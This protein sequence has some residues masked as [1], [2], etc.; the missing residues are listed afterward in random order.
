[1][2]LDLVSGS[3]LQNSS[4]LFSID[5]L[6]RLLWEGN[7]RILSLVKP[8]VFPDIAGWDIPIFN[9]KYIDSIRAHLLT[10]AGYVKHDPRVLASHVWLTSST[11]TG[12]TV[13]GDLQNC[14]P[15]DLSIQW[16]LAAN[17]VG[18]LALAAWHWAFPPPHNF[19][20]AG[21]DGI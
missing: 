1:M 21:G 7:C 20:V 10:P 14:G 17:A 8:L 5:D 18:P 12:A 3:W 11:R 15:K 4:L 19:M 2:V 13:W 9:R 16:T 6:S